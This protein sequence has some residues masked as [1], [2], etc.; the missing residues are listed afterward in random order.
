MNQPPEHPPVELTH[1]PPLFGKRQHPYYIFAPDYERTSSGVRVLHLLCHALNSIGHEAYVECR[2]TNPDWRTPCLTPEI[3]AEHKKA[4]VEPIVIY[5]EVVAGNPK[6]ARAVVRYLLYVPGLINPHATPD[7]YGEDDLIYAYGENLLEGLPE[8]RFLHLP[9]VDLADFPEPDP[10]LRVPGKVCYYMGRAASIRDSLDLSFLPQDAIEITK[11]YPATPE[12]LAHLFQTCETFYAFAGTSLSQEAA[13]CGCLAVVIPNPFIPVKSC[14]KECGYL[15]TAWGN[16]PEAIA[17]A[18]VSLARSR[19]LYTAQIDRFWQR[20]PAFI[21]NTQAHA[22]RFDSTDKHRTADNA[23]DQAYAFWRKNHTLTEVGAELLAERMMQGWKAQP[24]FHLLTCIGSED[25]AVLA[26]LIDSLSTQLYPQW[27]L[28][29]IADVPCPD[30]LFDEIAQ[31]EWHIAE[32]GLHGQAIQQGLIDHWRCDWAIFLPPGVHLAPHALL[33]LADYANLHPEWQL[34]YADDDAVDQTKHRSPRFRPGFDINHLRGTP[35]LGTLCVNRE[36]LTAAG[37]VSHLPRAA[38]YDTALRLNDHFGPQAIGHIA[39]VLYHYPPKV[40]ENDEAEEKQALAMHLARCNK[41]ETL[42]TGLRDHLFRVIP[43]LPENARVSLVT[44]TRNTGPWLKQFLESLVKYPAPLHEIII[45]DN[46]SD[47]PDSLA[48]LDTLADLPLPIVYHRLPAEQ[49][50]P[51]ALNTGA[52]I[53][54]GDFLLFASD[55]LRAAHANWLDAL[56][57]Q[58][59]RPE[60]GAV[61]A[62]LFNAGSGKLT[63]AGYVLGLGLSAASPFDSQLEVRDP[64][65]LAANLVERTVSAVSSDCLLMRRDVFEAAGGFDAATFQA[66]GHDID[67]CQRLREQGLATVWTPY[68]T[69][70]LA[71]RE[72]PIG[73][74]VRPEIQATIQLARIADDLKLVERW[75]TDGKPDHGWN[76]NLSL[77]H[78]DARAEND[79]VIDWDPNFCGRPKIMGLAM[80]GG[81]G[82]YRLIDPLEA[83]NTAGLAETLVVDKGYGR[84][85]LPGVVELAR[86]R[87]NTLYLQ[88]PL[89]DQQIELM[90]QY[91]QLLPHCR[92]VVSLDD[93]LDVVPETSSARKWLP[94][95]AKARFRAAVQHTDC[96]IVTTEPIAEWARN[97]VDDIRIIPNRL[98]RSRWDGLSSLRGAGKKPRVGWAGAMQHKG[99]LALVT[100]LVKATYQDIDWIFMGMCP[101]EIRAQVAEFH[102]FQARFSDYA[103][104]LAALNLDLAIAPLENNAFNESKSNLRLVE[105]GY[106]G[107]PVVCSDVLPYQDAPVCRVD[108]TAKAWREAV[109]ARVNDLQAAYR[110]GNELREWVLA[111][112]MLEDHTEDWL[113]ALT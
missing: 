11:T 3:E 89:G 102:R 37:G 38:D 67:L 2:I 60:V 92:Q 103:A 59:G 82:V 26:P 30:P 104:S 53:A 58:A 63:H 86:S 75:L 81:S 79:I 22:R 18:K 98:P 65:P 4:G 72:L 14:W 13:L 88:N 48:Y 84:S 110:E 35:Y 76:A 70:P 46:H 91:R 10:T 57:R 21:E 45:V 39:D 51:A 99:D 112:Y 9:V 42:S 50:G 52:S 19:E 69:L 28:S 55:H 8:E 101:D 40:P 106:L 85:R 7:T 25:M 62:R 43:P 111:R 34:L 15:G 94:L 77:I 109:L 83:L 96:L 16:T 27:H 23:I 41:G 78:G 97:M 56:L 47:D 1:V 12:D 93:R 6:N 68:A 44:V 74:D 80:Q 90:R 17:E 87:A 105:Y 73:H 64:G 29:V 61:G 32:D 100:E 66:T 71:T 36:A 24:R 33:K 107:W 108:N 31:L 20:L 95:N 54:Q 49:R 113:S 5:P